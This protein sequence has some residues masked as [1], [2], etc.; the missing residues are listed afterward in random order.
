MPKAYCPICTCYLNILDMRL[1]GCGHGCCA[2]CISQLARQACPACRRP[3]TR[4]DPYTLHVEVLEDADV[5]EPIET[6]TRRLERVLTGTNLAVAKAA[7]QSLQALAEKLGDEGKVDA[8]VLNAAISLLD[9]RVAP[10]LNHI[11]NQRHTIRELMESV[12]RGL[13]LD[14]D[15]KTRQL[16]RRLERAEDERDRARQALRAAGATL[17]AARED[18]FAHPEVLAVRE[19]RDELQGRLSTVRR[20]LDVAL[21]QELARKKRNPF[22]QSAMQRENQSLKSRVAELEQKLAN[23]ERPSLRLRV[24]DNF[25]T[26]GEDTRTRH[27]PFHPQALGLDLR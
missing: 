16:Q 23:A 2:R 14:R 22:A 24:C 10:L 19:E 25:N 9:K 6:A 17:A 26:N 4:D 27:E 15:L 3:F 5:P 18:A 12:D 7:Q 1:F 13:P 21:E 8:G 20:Q 11:T